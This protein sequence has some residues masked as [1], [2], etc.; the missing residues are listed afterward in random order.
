[1][2]NSSPLPSYSV[3]SID[4]LFDIDL[5]NVTLTSSS[6]INMNTVTINSSYNI[7]DTIT[8]GE[9]AF[10]WGEATEWVDAFPDWQRVQDMCQKYPGLE[11]ALRNFQTV[12]TLVKDDY[13]NPKDEK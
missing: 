7:N 9:Y 8:I 13:D 6:D 11:V 2:S 12:Y 4:N 5:N 3:T 10:N 1:M